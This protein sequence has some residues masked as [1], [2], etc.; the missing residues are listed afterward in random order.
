M[1]ASVCR[2]NSVVKSGYRNTGPVVR[3][4]LARSKAISHLNHSE[5][6][7]NKPHPSQKTAR[8]QQVTCFTLPLLS[9][10]SPEP[11]V[12]S[13]RL[14]QVTCFTL[15]LLS[16]RSGQPRVQ[17]GRVKQLTTLTLSLPATCGRIIKKFEWR[18]ETL[19][20]S[21]TDA[22]LTSVVLRMFDYTLH[23]LT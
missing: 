23:R 13:A 19:H 4:C 9:A 18:N 3:A 16:A 1:L 17:T 7:C 21:H 10:R 14:Q 11:C 2:Q 5:P 12:P 15:A 22:M 8:V 6:E 20:S